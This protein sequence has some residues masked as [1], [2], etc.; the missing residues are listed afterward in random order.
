M[1]DWDVTPKFLLIYWLSSQ[2]HNVLFASYLSTIP[3]NALTWVAQAFSFELL[4]EHAQFWDHLDIYDMGH[5]MMY[6]L[7]VFTIVE[8]SMDDLHHI[9]PPYQQTP[10]S[11]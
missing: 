8:F 9:Y 11:G 10:S 4:V 6:K 2:T 5:L 3:T 7:R 1:Q